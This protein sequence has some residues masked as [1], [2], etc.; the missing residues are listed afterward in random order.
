[1]FCTETAAATEDESNGVADVSSE[2]FVLFKKTSSNRVSHFSR[3]F[4]AVGDRGILLLPDID[5]NSAIVIDKKEVL[6]LSPASPQS[7]FEPLSE[8]RK[9]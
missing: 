2:T 7:V 1:V 3:S 8:P 6:S 5:A 9:L 4:S